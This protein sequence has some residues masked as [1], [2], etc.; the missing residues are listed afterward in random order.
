MRAARRGGKAGIVAASLAV[1]ALVF[2]LVWTHAVRLRIPVPPSGP[3]QAIIPVLIMPRVPPSPAAAP[4]ARPAE[5]RL[6]RRPQRFVAELPPVA[7]LVVPQLPE[8]DKKPTGP[9]GPRVLTLPS[10]KDAVAE[11]TRKALR[12]RLGCAN[13]DALGLSRSEREACENELARGA[14]ASDFQGF[15]I[16]ADKAGGLAAAAAEKERR[17]KYMRSSG[18]VGTAGAGPSATENAPGGRTNLPGSSAAGIAGSVGADRPT[19]TTPF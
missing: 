10:A 13:A 7:P 8:E 5:I 1:H 3:P 19:R 15:G 9:S 14:Q 16:D 18:G 2:A 4:G 17:Y 6:H 11:N 12:G